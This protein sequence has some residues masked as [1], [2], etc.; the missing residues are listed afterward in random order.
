VLQVPL[1]VKHS[2][3][4]PPEYVDYEGGHVAY[5]VEVKRLTKIVERVLA[6]SFA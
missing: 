5:S 4:A 6:A 3:T 1:H 2:E